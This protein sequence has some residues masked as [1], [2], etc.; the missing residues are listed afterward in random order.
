VRLLRPDM[1][2]RSGEYA[3]HASPERIRSGP[4]AAGI[5]G[6]TAAPSAPLAL[7]AG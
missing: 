4:A 2:T 1:R 7:D 3:A 6:R 5:G